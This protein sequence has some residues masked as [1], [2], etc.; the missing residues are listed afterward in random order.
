MQAFATTPLPAFSAPIF[1]PNTHNQIIL[2]ALLT[3]C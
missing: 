2:D 3:L 1:G